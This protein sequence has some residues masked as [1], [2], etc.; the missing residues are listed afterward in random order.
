M[1]KR[2]VVF[3]IIALLGLY[4][5]L[6]NSIANAQMYGMAPSHLS[7]V[8][9]YHPGL[10]S[11]TARLKGSIGKQPADILGWNYVEYYPPQNLCY[12]HYQAQ[13]P[14]KG[15]TAAQQVPCPLG[16]QP[17]DSYKVSFAMAIE[18]MHTLDCGSEFVRMSLSWPVTPVVKEPIWRIMTNLGNEILIGA[19]SGTI[20]QCNSQQ[21][22]PKLLQAPDPAAKFCVDSGYQ[23]EGGMCIFPDGSKCEEWAFYRG[24]C[25]QKFTYCEKQGN[26]VESR[27]ETETIKDAQ[28]IYAICK[29]PDG[30]ECGEEDYQQGK[31]KPGECKQWTLSIG[32]MK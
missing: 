13:F 11:Q 10:I 6:V 18:I 2:K 21:P 31:C 12:A 24:E 1:M 28:F 25:G 30:T 29:F 14:L 20:L 22:I 27:V 32:C 8:M 4:T 26:K 5:I 3:G 19:N 17:F 7:S 23:Y 15:A 16:V 9:L